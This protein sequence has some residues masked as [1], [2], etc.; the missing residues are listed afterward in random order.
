MSSDLEE[1]NAKS[2]M[3]ALK[4]QNEQLV[5]FQEQLTGLANSIGI[6]QMR[7]EELRKENV[8]QLVAR[9]GTGSTVHLDGD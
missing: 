2:V 6:L 7:F 9:L 4:G 3:A 8:E 1:R 5:R